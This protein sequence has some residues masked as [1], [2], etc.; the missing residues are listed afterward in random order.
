MSTRKTTKRMTRG[1]TAI[2]AL[3]LAGGLAAC[4]NSPEDARLRGQVVGGATGAA[5]GS[6][7]GRGT[8]KIAATGAGAVL[9][10]IAGGKI[11]G[12]M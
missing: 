4:S 7:F 11:A 9:G 1:V 8:G 12:E 10:T 5:L 2:A 3:A 6:L